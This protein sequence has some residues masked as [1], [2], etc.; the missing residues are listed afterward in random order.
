M[1]SQLNEQKVQ[2]E[3][4]E[5]LILRCQSELKSL[6]TKISEKEIAL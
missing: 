1:N 3:N 2:I 4:G 6:L 5:G